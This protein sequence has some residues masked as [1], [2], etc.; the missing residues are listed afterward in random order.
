MKR[1]NEFLVFFAG[2]WRCFKDLE[3][4]VLRVALQKDVRALAV[5]RILSS[6]PRLNPVGERMRSHTKKGPRWR[7]R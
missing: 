5:E 4:F 3:G 6:L 1:F 2:A 7:R